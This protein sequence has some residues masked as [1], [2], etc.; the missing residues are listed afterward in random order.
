MEIR[1]LRFVVTLA[2]ELHF[3]RAARG[4]TSL[5]SRSGSTSG[6]LSGRSAPACSNAPVVVWS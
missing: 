2:E 1:T 3:G 4:T 6:A 5:L